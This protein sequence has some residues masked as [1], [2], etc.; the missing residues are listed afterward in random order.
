[1]TKE[2]SNQIRD[3]CIELFG[4][5]IDPELT[6]P[7]EKFGDFASN[8][9]LRLGKKLDKNPRD[10]AEEI[11]SNISGKPG[12]VI[13]E[14]KVEGPGFIN[15]RIKDSSLFASAVKPNRTEPLDGLTIVAEYS[16]PNPF[17]VL[18]AGHLYTTLVGDAIANILQEAGGDVH[19]VNYGGDVGLHVAK[20]MWAIIEK[21]GGEKPQQLSNVADQQKLAWLSER[22]AEGNEAYEKGGHKV[23]AIKALNKRIYA[24]HI[25]GDKDSPFAKIYWTCRQ[26]S[27]DGFELLYERLGVGKFEKYYPESSVAELGMKTVR[28]HTGDVYEESDGAVVYRGEGEGL[29]T[30]VFITKDGIPTYEAK[31]VGLILQK[32]NDYDF[33][34]SIVL[35]DN[36]QM[37]YMQV[38]LAS[39]R[40]FEPQLA[41]R[42]EHITHGV[43]KLAG[44]VKMSSRRG[45]FLTADNVLEAARQA[46]VEARG[47]NDPQVTLGAVK[48]ALLK[49]KIGGDIIY[50]PQE[51]VSIEGNSGPY[52]QY[53]LVRAKSILKKAAAQKAAAD[54]REL[55][56]QERTLAR[57]LSQFP[58][59]LEEASKELSLH[60]I[61]GYLYETSQVFNSFYENNRVIGDPRSDVRLA[62]VES[63]KSILEKGLSILGVPTPE[64]M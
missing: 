5:D 40:K 52:L 56:A 16:D 10:L 44:G 60:H 38:V 17:K 37:Q 64:S 26:W 12:G 25:D 36:S 8:V 39:V 15:L 24:I 50:N 51:S 19:R 34:K 23:N 55:Q 61:C 1:M 9:A 45:N 14:T 58:E 47:Q 2:L 30:R 33:D 29:H 13:A 27:Y 48:Y 3:I 41:D 49:N 35:T 54:S 43:I 11:S 63:Y 4:E 57:Q 21:I 62:L 18:H 7:D 42:T 32:R 53:A 20:C 46:S 6:R 59:I 28:Q 31:D 22:Y